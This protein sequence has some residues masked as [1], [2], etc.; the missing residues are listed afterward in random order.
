MRERKSS[1]LQPRSLALEE[2]KKKN[3]RS[4]EIPRLRSLKHS[5]LCST[6]ALLERVKFLFLSSL[7]KLSAQGFGA[8][9]PGIAA[10]KVVDEK[11]ENIRSEVST[12]FW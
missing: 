3:L 5:P 4:K 6:S 9:D 8:S 12:L 7:E 1:S 10:Q 11:K 2:E